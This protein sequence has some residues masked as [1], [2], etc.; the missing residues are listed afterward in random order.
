MHNIQ[1]FG[2]PEMTDCGA[3]LR[4]LGA[5]A[6][7]MEEAAAEVVHYLH[8]HLIDGETGARAMVLVRLF[9]T[10]IYQDLDEQLRAFADGMLD[11]RPSAPNMKC[12]TLLASAG[13]EPEWNSRAS[14]SGYQAIPLPSV[15]LVRQFPMIW[16]LV[17]QLGL[18]IATLL[19]PD[20][21]CLRDAEQR[22]C[23]VFLVSQTPG[24][25]YIPA[26]KAFVVPY[27]VESTLGFGGVFPSGEWFA[28][29]MFS[30]ITIAR[31]TADLFQPLALAVKLALLPFDHAVFSRCL[32]T[33]GP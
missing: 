22:T 3:V 1:D 25:P 15:E 29:I 11:G 23:S 4:K 19:D 10:H 30:R 9:K 13:Q 12:L 24:S 27:G 28:V 21:S 2:I 20:P 16:N 5:N 6:R 33:C 8:D 7:S 17:K 32:E 14:S 18:E 26:Q 31:E